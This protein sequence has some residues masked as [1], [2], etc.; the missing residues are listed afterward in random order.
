MARQTKAL[1]TTL[2]RAL[3]AHGRTYAD[4]ATALDLSEAS[5]KRLLSTN[6]LSLERLE[7]IG[8]LIGLEITDLVKQMEEETGRIERLT[9]EQER[10]I[11]GDLTLLLITV[12]VLN[13]WTLDDILQVHQLDPH[14][15][16]RKLARLDKLQLIDLLPRNRV[17]LK[18]AANFN[19]I[20]NGPIQQF[21]QQRI[22]SEYFNSRFQAED[23]NLIVL[24]GMLSKS[25]N[26]AFQR[27]MQRLAREFEEFNREDVSLDFDTR[28][29]TTVIIA[30]RGWRYGLFK[31]DVDKA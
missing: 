7:A 27:R 17:K 2:K 15:C 19:W 9:V 16:T 22:A 30:I 14:T 26:Q 25:S 6:Q 21:F 5:V 12:C 13:R 31:T 24:N 3:K 23:E 20:E 11:A 4:V 18:V 8:Q 1:I 29:G 28:H 10:E